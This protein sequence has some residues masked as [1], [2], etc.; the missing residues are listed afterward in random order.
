MLKNC[1]ET[2]QGLWGRVQK[3][4]EVRHQ[5]SLFLPTIIQ[6]PVA[7]DHKIF[8]SEFIQINWK[9]FFT[10]H[11]TMFSWQS[12]ESGCSFSHTKMQTSVTWVSHFDPLIHKICI[13]LACVT[14]LCLLRCQARSLS[15]G[16]KL[17]KF[18][19]Q[20]HLQPCTNF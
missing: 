9:I 10:L 12:F 20:K 8:V 11:W 7:T 6:T 17:L 19:V 5:C 16:F 14:Y 3:H 2:K 1:D 4:Q 15:L 13:T 18:L